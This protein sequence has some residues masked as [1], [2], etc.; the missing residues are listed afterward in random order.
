MPT[1]V[2]HTTTV[3]TEIEQFSNKMYSGYRNAPLSNKVG[4]YNNRKQQV[5]AFKQFEEME[6]QMEMKIK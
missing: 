2:W 5:D 1:T 3:N 4:I 6:L